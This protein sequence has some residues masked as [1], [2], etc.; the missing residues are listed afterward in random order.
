M[1]APD[2]TAGK[3]AARPKDG[4]KRAARATAGPAKAG[5]PDKRGPAKPP[6]KRAG[7]KAG[8]KDDAAVAAEIERAVE[9]E[10]KAIE[11]ILAQVGDC[12]ERTA[13]AERTAR[14]L[15]S[16]TRTLGAVRRLRPAGKAGK[17]A[18]DEA[19]ADDDMPRDIDEFRR[20]LARRIDA[21]VAGHADAA[22]PD[23]G[24]E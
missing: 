24:G 15:A 17:A 23:G 2:T 7:T 6:R 19:D 16:L 12:D 11:A 8:A 3:A 1:A 4:R 22:V 18:K 20:E 14:T 10:L 9:R 5:G 21:F 13:F